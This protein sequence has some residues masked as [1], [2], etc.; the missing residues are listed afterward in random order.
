MT[1]FSKDSSD[2]LQGLSKHSN[3]EWFTDHKNDY[4]RY[5]KAPSE[6]F[7][8]EMEQRLQTLTGH[9]YN[10]KL[11]RI[12]RDVR[13]SKDK[14]PYHFTLIHAYCFLMFTTIFHWFLTSAL[15]IF[16][17]LIHKSASE[18]LQ[19]ESHKSLVQ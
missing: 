6:H 12:Y 14:T 4:E 16:L 10:S 13:F 19:I 17:R 7:A 5:I 2:F 1:L 15:G 11:F 9:E 18:L 3:R 8:A